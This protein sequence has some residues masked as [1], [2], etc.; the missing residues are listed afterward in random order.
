MTAL[1]S[2]GTTPLLIVFAWSLITPPM[3]EPQPLHPSYNQEERGKILLIGWVP[4]ALCCLDLIDQNSVIWSSLPRRLSKAIWVL[5]SP[6]SWVSVSLPWRK[7]KD[8]RN[9]LTHSPHENPSQRATP[10]SLLQP[11]PTQVGKGIKLASFPASKWA[12][13]DWP[14]GPAGSIWLR[15]GRH[16]PPH[17]SDGVFQLRS[18]TGH[19]RR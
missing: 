3:P 18:S 10:P 16:P 5:G 7:G 14:L 19:L 8:F 4:P 12:G 6:G 1:W 15:R 13:L 11:P 9:G 17:P 2:S